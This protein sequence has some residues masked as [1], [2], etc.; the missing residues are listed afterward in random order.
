MPSTEEEFDKLT[1]ENNELDSLNKEAEVE[2][3]QLQDRYQ[4]VKDD[5]ESKLS[6]T[7]K[8]LKSLMTNINDVS[9]QKEVMKH[10]KEDFQI[11]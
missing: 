6:E 1:S 2:F 10:L 11:S 9:A 7:M 4:E 5:I 8:S 3:N